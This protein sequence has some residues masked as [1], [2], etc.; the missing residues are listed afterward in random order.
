[1]PS[2]GLEPS[3]G[4]PVQREVYV[5]KLTKTSQVTQSN[6]FF[7]VPDEIIIKKISS[8]DKGWFSCELPPGKYSLFTKE[9][10]GL[11]AN[12]FDGESNIN[13]VT[14]EKGEITEC[15]ITINYKAYY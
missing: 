6:D 12:I 2:P 7:Q 11:F 9:E 13:P 15:T 5:C 4:D 8:D 14:V 1:M 10:D 3:K